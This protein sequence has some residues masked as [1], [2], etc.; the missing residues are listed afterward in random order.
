MRIKELPSRGLAL[1]IQNGALSACMNRGRRVIYASCTKIPEGKKAPVERTHTEHR[2]VATRTQSY[3]Y[4]GGIYYATSNMSSKSSVSLELIRVV[5]I[6]AEVCISLRI[7]ANSQLWRVEISRSLFC[8]TDSEFFI[9]LKCLCSI[10]P[11]PPYSPS[12]GYT[13]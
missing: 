1:A 2:F 5:L 3:K 10:V 8:K 6:P 7:P 13:S 4:L 9:N 12:D 11:P